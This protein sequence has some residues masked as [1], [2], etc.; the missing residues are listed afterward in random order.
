GDNEPNRVIQAALLRA[1]VD[2]I[3]DLNPAI[4]HQKF[5]V[6][7]PGEPTAGVLT[8]S[9]NFTLTDTGQNPAGNTV[10]TGN[11]LNHIVVLHG[12]RIAEQ[13]L[14][15]FT[16][17]RSGTFGAMHERVEP[18][19]AEFPLAKIRVKPL[20]APQHGPEMEIMKQM[21][22]AR[23]RVDFAMFTFA[24]SSGIDDTM[25]R[26]VG[27]A[28]AIRG[29]LDHGQG[30]QWWAATE[31]LKAAGVQLW[32]N[33][34]GTGVRKVHHKLMVIDEQLIIVGSLNYTGPATTINDENIVVLGDLEEKDPAAQA[35]QR[36]LAAAALTEINR[37]ITDLGRPL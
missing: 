8:G 24:Q 30:R 32:E 36:H 26:L 16:R 5:I 27:P 14:A 2:L 13:Y 31:P 19:P 29:I 18:R 20:F 7:D 11:N 6:R 15:E 17:L 28:F 10:K 3:S 34:P 35:L 25:A 12:Q 23:E 1:G 9:T 37:I 21:L 4:F 22:K 33:R